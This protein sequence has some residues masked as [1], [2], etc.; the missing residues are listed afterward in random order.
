MCSFPFACSFIH[1]VCVM[2]FLTVPVAFWL[3]LLPVST[4]IR[5]ARTTRGAGHHSRLCRC[6]L[7][8]AA[9]RGIGIDGAPCGEASTGSSHYPA[10]GL[11]ALH[12]WSNDA[13]ETG[14]VTGLRNAGVTRDA[15]GPRSLAMNFC[16]RESQSLAITTAPTIGKSLMADA[17]CASSLPANTAVVTMRWRRLLATLPA[18]TYGAGRR[19]WFTQQGT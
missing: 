11:R 9:A 1:S 19:T 17:S 2:R 18:Q 16:A 4:A 6:L 5:S 15:K 10:H 3:V 7:L 13:K 14:A 8:A 12:A